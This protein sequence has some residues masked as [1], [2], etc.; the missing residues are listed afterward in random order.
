MHDNPLLLHRLFDALDHHDHRT[1]AS[2]YHSAANFRDIAFDLR[3][4]KQIHSMWHMICDGDIRA[5]Y[6]VVDAN[7]REGRVALVDTYTFGGAKDPPKKGRPVR[8][9]VDSRFV[10]QDGL[11]A[12]HHDFCDARE[13]ARS[14][15]G[16]SIGFLAGRIPFLRSRT[17][18]KKLRTFVEKHPEYR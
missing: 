13:W 15:L 8:N 9:V 2:C 6:E 10:F 14:A 18:S 17:A 12:R 5:T 3:G 11:I 16:G 1:M 4:K 7:D